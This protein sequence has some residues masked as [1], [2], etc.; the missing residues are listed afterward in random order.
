M[1]ARRDGRAV[2]H[3]WSAH[4]TIAIHFVLRQRQLIVVV[5]HVF[6]NQGHV[7]AV[8]LVRVLL[9]SDG[10]AGLLSIL[11]LVLVLGCLAREEV[12]ID[13]ERAVAL[14]VVYDL[15]MVYIASKIPINIVH[16]HLLLTFRT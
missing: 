3:H 12:V 8:R 1:A 6:L 9:A 13:V 2:Y 4:S 11:D 15:F 10:H 14:L 5:L 7:V 16:M